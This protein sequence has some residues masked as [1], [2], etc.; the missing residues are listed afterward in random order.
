[1]KEK[2]TPIFN[3]TLYQQGPQKIQSV[4][5]VMISMIEWAV[6]DYD[7]HS[8]Q[9]QMWFLSQEKNEAGCLCK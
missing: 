6:K 8:P 5:E 4:I 3:K 1:M 2:V 9:I 7:H